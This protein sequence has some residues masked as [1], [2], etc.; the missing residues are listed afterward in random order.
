MTAVAAE[1]LD[2]GARIDVRDDQG[3]TSLHL[4]TG[5]GDLATSR[6]LVERGAPLELKNAYGGTALDSLTMSS[7]AWP[8]TSRRG[9]GSSGGRGS[10]WVWF[11]L[12]SARI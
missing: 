12:P 11:A 7:S 10:L 8:T 1:L 3:M 6:M 9:G 2:A 5:R 4:A